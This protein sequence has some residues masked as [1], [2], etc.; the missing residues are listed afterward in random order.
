MNKI[1]MKDGK[2]TEITDEQKAKLTVEELA[3][4]TTDKSKSVTDALKAEIQV[5]TDNASKYA[6]KE[7]ITNQ[8]LAITAKIDAIKPDVSKADFEEL[9]G[10]MKKMGADVKAIQEPS[11]KETN[12]S[13]QSLISKE[14]TKAKDTIA[15]FKS[16]D[17]KNH[18]V[19]TVKGTILRVNVVD[20]TEAHR[21]AGIGQ[22][23]RRR[24]FMRELFT[25]ASVSPNNHGVIRYTDQE[26]LTD[27]SAQIAEG[28][29]FP[30]SDIDWK[31]RQLPIE[32]TG[33][34]IKISREMMDDVDYV[35][36]EIENFLLRN[37][38][39]KVDSQLLLGTG[40]S[41]Q[42]K[43]MATSATAFAAGDFAASVQDANH[44]DLI[45]IIASQ[46]MTGTDYMPNAVEMHPTDATKMKLK[47]DGEN[48]YVIPSFIVPTPSGD[49]LVDGMVVVPNSGVAVDTMYVGDFTR[50]TVYSSGQ[51]QIEMGY[52]NDD[53]TKDLVTVKARE[54]LALLIRN[55]DGGAF[56]KVASIDTA[57]AAIDNTP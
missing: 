28:V 16:E 55:V 33:D 44:F 24:P 15:K 19:F 50:G 29:K 18:L 23:Q 51:V 20:N 8:G 47:K 27:N 11:T 14:L 21:V 26:N 22:I 17:S 32:K 41:P 3:V 39:L 38:K 13:L 57:L 53:F 25:A 2:F 34:S 52:E 6:S 46:I 43:G 9:Q 40:V 7:D 56:V 36:S 5:L 45:T 37:V 42:L 48:N 10:I 54:R 49:I 31:E 4:Y 30:S 35:M 12:E 1:W